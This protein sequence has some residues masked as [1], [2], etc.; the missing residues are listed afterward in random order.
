MNKK[1]RCEMNEK[2]R[3][4]NRSNEKGSRAA[5]SIQWIHRKRRSTL[6]ARCSG[7]TAFSNLLSL[8]RDRTLVTLSVSE[9][10]G[11]NT[12]QDFNLRA[13]HSRSGRMIGYQNFGRWPRFFLSFIMRQQQQRIKAYSPLLSD[14]F[15]LNYA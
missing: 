5:G 12:E 3:L 1:S 2:N 6:V 14:V 7:S 13:E 8:R 10:G 15:R 4:L 11:R 9:F